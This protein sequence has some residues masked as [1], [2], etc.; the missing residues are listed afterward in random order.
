M[1]L[2]CVWCVRFDG[3][4]LFVC[5]KKQRDGHTGARTQDHSVIS[6]ALYRLS[7]TT[8]LPL[9]HAK[10]TTY[11]HT[12]QQ[13]KQHTQNTHN[14]QQHNTTT[15]THRHPHSHPQTNTRNSNI[16]TPNL[17]AKLSSIHATHD[18]QNDSLKLALSQF[19]I[20]EST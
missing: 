16:N 1:A 8:S 2:R 15:N 3:R 4:L 12:I 19:L 13:T 11:L 9:P 17:F 14:T 18:T 10:H 5:C 20:I 7:Y 6:T